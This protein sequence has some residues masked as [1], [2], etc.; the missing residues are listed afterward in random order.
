MSF[1]SNKNVGR[2]ERWLSGIGAGAMIAAGLKRR[3]LPALGMAAVGGGWLLVRS[4]TGHCPVYQKLGIDTSGKRPGQRGIHPAAQ[5]GA[6]LQPG[7]TRG[8]APGRPMSEPIDVVQEA[9]E[10][11]FPASDAP[12]WTRSGME[13]G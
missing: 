4:I 9:S 3:S 7:E 8:T 11:S 1:W 13:S 5:S 6:S 2:M 10:E 12:G